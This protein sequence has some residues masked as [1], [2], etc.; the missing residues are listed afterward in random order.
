MPPDINDRRPR[1]GSGDHDGDHDVSPNL[2]AGAVSGRECAWCRGEL[3][4]RRRRF[5]SDEHRRKGQ[6]RERVIEN[7]DYAKAAVRLIRSMGKR[8]SA[9][10][11]ALEWLAGA[12]DYARD[13]LAMA[14]DG[15]R[16]RGYSDGEIGAALGITRQAVWKRFPRQ[17]KVDA[18]TPESGAAG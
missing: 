12:V 14:V 13:A 4:P 7:D 5:C 11:E 8:A 15:C 9:D 2:Q 16:A 1:A 17:P 3:P 18:G 10:L 6:K